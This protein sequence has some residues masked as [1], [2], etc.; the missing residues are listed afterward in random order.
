MA[1]RNLSWHSNGVIVVMVTAS[2]LVCGSALAAPVQSSDNTSPRP[3]SQTYDVRQSQHESSAH[4]NQNR[5]WRPY[6]GWSS[7]WNGGWGLGWHSGWNNGWGL[8]WN[9]GW[10]N[11]YWHSPYS[12][13]GVSV[14]YQQPEP[15]AVAPVERVTTSVQ[16]ST[17]RKSL[18]A[19]ARVK[20]QDGR[21]VY[22]W[23]GTSYYFDWQSQT[24]LEVK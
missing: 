14:P 16:Y 17:G 5:H 4:H 3:V 10:G 8:G 12:G 11:N 7:A 13:I 18:P 23:Q 9:N 6:W 24:Y 19:N 15:V 20:Q 1:N 22:E 21:T 2:F